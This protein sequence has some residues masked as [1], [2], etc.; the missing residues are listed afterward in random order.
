MPAERGRR[1]VR[2]SQHRLHRDAVPEC[3][4]HRLLPLR[5]GDEAGWK[6]AIASAATLAPAEQVALTG[7]VFAALYDGQANAGDVVALVQALAPVARW[8]VL[9]SCNAG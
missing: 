4:R 8:D 5:A 1:R 2:A 7:N 9:K 6:A 3:R